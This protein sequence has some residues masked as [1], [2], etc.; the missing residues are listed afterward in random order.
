M[1][2]DSFEGRDV[3]ATSSQAQLDEVRPALDSPVTATIEQKRNTPRSGPLSSSSQ[4]HS[5]DEGFRVHNR[6]EFQFGKVCHLPLFLPHLFASELRCPFQIFRVY[7][8]EPSGSVESVGDVSRV[9]T[10]QRRFVVISVKQ[11]HSLCLQVVS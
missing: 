6:W 11:G 1:E 10:V 5:T 7:W 4:R 3:P 8:A 9:W 2:G